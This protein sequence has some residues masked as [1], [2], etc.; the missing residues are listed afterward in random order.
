MKRFAALLDGLLLTPSRNGKLRLLREYFAATPDP[1]RGWAL[2]ALTAE[3]S[4]PEVKPSRIRDL[5]VERVDPVLLRWSWDFVGDLAETVALLWPVAPGRATDGDAPSPDGGPS[6]RLVVVVERLRSATRAEAPALL[7][8]LLD[9]LDSSGRYALLKLVTGELR[10]GVSARLA[11]IAL[12][13][14]AAPHGIALDEVEE[15]WHGLAP[16]YGG[17]FEWIEGRAPRPAVAERA[18]FRPLM[19]AQPIEEDEL[20]SLDPAA[21]RAEW[22]WDGIRVQLVAGEGVAHVY[23]RSGDEIGGAFPEIVAALR[24]DAVLDGELLVG[25]DGVPAPFGDLQQRLNRKTVSRKLA[26]ELPAFVRVYDI[27]FDGGEDLRALAFAERRDRL[28]AWFDRVRPE[29][30]DLSP[31]VPF[32]DWDELRAL[33]AGV[34]PGAIEGLV[35]K[36]ADSPYVAGRPKG[37]WFKWKRGPVLIDAVLMYAQRGSGKRSSYY[38]DYTFGVWKDG[39]LVPVGKA[40]FGFSDDELLQLDRWIRSH[41]VAKHG[42][43][44]EVA[45]ELVLEVACD[46]LQRSTRHRSGLA[47]RFPR[48]HR[49][50]WDKPA[51]EA[52]RLETLERIVEKAAAGARA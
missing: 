43:V 49:I 50:R 6:P 16:P 35:L 9:A 34:G 45:R 22:K 15:V 44:R 42:P 23:S 14:L 30:L 2:A 12:A 38:S 29:R 18:R 10:V 3:L 11:K 7:A 51:A 52:E 17:L 25:R 47:M 36:R 31:L 27:L 28:V 37:P 1:D 20:V 33:Y 8:E 24:F 26:E 4:L 46:G 5:A 40:Y 13:E 21:Y 19:L 41:T 32:R 39:A 48:I